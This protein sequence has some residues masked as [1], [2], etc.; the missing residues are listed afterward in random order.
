MRL[1]GAVAVLALLAPTAHAQE[2]LDLAGRVVERAGLDAQLRSIPGQFEQGLAD[3]RGKIPDEM[4]AALAEAGKKSFA[5]EPL[6]GEIVRALAQKLTAADMKQALVWL[7]GEAGRRLTA[8]EEGA[9][10]GMTP[11]AMQEFFESEKKNPS[12]AK[13]EAMIADLIEATRAVEVGAAFVEAISLGVA[14]GMDA[15]QPVEKRL[16]APALRSRLRAAMPPE[17]VRADV[18]AILPPMY[19]YV[20]RSI[21]DADLAAYVEFNRSALGARYNEALTA[22]LAGALTAASV[23]VGEMLPAAPTREKI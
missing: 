22:A 10:G 19:R 6:R 14:V 3:Y 9:A 18:S 12:S 15:T 23:R 16:G 5:A 11:E 17:R 1:W 2:T 20:Y 8:A 4:I 13:R 21:G 7:E